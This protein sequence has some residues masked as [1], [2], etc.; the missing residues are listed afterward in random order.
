MEVASAQVPHRW[1]DL[2]GA[3]EN[4]EMQQGATLNEAVKSRPSRTY[5][6]FADVE[7]LLRTEWSALQRY[8]ADC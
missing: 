8:G 5:S 4:S 1:E 7:R 6:S 2:S 3:L